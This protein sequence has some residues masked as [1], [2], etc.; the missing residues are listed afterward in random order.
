MVLDPS[1]QRELGSAARLSDQSIH[2]WRSNGMRTTKTPAG[3]QSSFSATG[4]QELALR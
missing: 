1:S 2:S 3:D 4:Q